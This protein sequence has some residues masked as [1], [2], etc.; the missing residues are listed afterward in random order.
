M[1]LLLFGAKNQLSRINR[2]KAMR[3]FAQP[4]HFLTS[5]DCFRQKKGCTRLHPIQRKAN[6][7]AS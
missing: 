2:T 1:F 7:A 6:L 4:I 5:C 3:A